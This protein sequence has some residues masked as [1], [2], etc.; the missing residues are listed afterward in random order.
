VECLWCFWGSAIILEIR[1][2][3]MVN[4]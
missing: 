3:H 2:G 1:L 4:Q